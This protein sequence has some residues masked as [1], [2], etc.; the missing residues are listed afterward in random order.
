VRDPRGGDDRQQQ[1]NDRNA[2]DMRVR[3]DS[4]LPKNIL[5]LTKHTA[6]YKIETQNE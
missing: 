1:V 2:A 3:A 4:R 6:V 5:V